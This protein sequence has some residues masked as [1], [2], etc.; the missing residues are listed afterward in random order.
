MIGSPRCFE[1]KCRW[2]LGVRG[3]GD[4]SSQRLF[5]W[6][7]QGRTKEDAI[8]KEIAFGDDL[9]EVPL[10]GQSNNTYIYEEDERESSVIDIQR[11]ID[12]KEVLRQ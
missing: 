3:D 10:P 6:A 1:R 4:E 12:R 11:F 7:F 9:H 5:C 8:P 2:F